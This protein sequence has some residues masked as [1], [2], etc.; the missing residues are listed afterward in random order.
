MNQ[1]SEAQADL[2]AKRSSELDAREVY[3]EAR[4]KLR[5]RTDAQVEENNRQIVMQGKRLE[6]RDKLEKDQQGRITALELAYAKKGAALEAEIFQKEER[7]G[8]WQVKIQKAKEELK[9]VNENVAGRKQYYQE[10]EQLI[11]K[12]AEDGNLQLRGLEYEIIEARQVI[13]DLKTER[14]NLYSERKQV[15]QDIDSAHQSF[16]V[17]L[18]I[19]LDTVRALE[20]QKQ[21]IQSEID[22]VSQHL[23]QLRKEE[24]AILIKRQQI[25][26]DIDAKLQALDEKERKI[27]AE[28]EA[29]RQE[30][31]DMQ[32]ERHYYKSSKSLY[33][34]P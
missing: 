6:E 14:V 2:L 13:K 34:L 4:E 22:D 32:Q 33:D 9:S 30:R 21:Q 12:Q 26:D 25:H 15:Q 11:A 24:A 16:A 17:E 10:Q 27:M 1:S 19:H 31:E 3:I 28:R 23:K 7:Y 20:A 18:E 8:D 5:E 29:L